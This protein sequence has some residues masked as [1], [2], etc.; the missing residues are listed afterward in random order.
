MQSR[1]NREWMPQATVERTEPEAIEGVE[2][3]MEA[4]GSVADADT[5]KNMLNPMVSQYR[6]WIDSQKIQAQQ[7]TDRRREIA[8]ELVSRA[9]WVAT[10]IE[11]GI[12]MLGRTQCTG[13]HFALP[14]ARWQPRAAAAALLS[15]V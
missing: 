7:F 11:A 10:R 2:F 14:T 8:D 3:S 12:N 4:L 6:A 15:E 9:S 13:R 1:E 5:A